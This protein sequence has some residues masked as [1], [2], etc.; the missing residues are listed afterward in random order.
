MYPNLEVKLIPIHP[1]HAELT[2]ENE[3]KKE[4][5]SDLSLSIKSGDLGHKS[6]TLSKVIKENIEVI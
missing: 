6:Q 4:Y 3:P 5:Y 2:K 1:V